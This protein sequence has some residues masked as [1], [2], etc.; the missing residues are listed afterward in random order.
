MAPLSKAPSKTDGGKG[1]PVKFATGDEKGMKAPAVKDMGVTNE[2][3]YKQVKDTVGE[4]E[5][6]F[7]GTGKNTPGAKQVNKHSILSKPVKNQ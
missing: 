1:Q 5:G 4:A 2:G 7:V 3:D 6:D